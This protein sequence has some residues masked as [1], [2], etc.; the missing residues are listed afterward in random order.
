MESLVLNTKY[1]ENSGEANLV[2]AGLIFFLFHF[3][4]RSP[5]RFLTKS[6]CISGAKLFSEKGYWFQEVSRTK[7]A[8]FLVGCIEVSHFEGGGGV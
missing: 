4:F 1:L 6:N 3:H 8:I 5:L 7:R 2:E